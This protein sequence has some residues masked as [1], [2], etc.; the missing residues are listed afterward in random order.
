MPTVEGAGLGQV[1]LDQLTI[2]LFSLSQELAEKAGD[3]FITV[4]HILL[5]TALLEDSQAAK[6]LE[7]NG[8]TPQS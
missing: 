4:E 8:V 3:S 1:Y 5:G 2:K 6:I 7:I